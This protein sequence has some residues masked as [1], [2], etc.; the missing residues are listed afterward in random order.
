VRALAE[1]RSVVLASA[2]ASASGPSCAPAPTNP[3]PLASEVP[4]AEEGPSASLV[5]AGA[6]RVCMHDAKD[7]APCTEDCDRGVVFACTIVATRTERGDGV[8]KDLTRAVQLYERACEL[9]DGP[10]CVSAARMYASGRG[11]PPSRPKQIQLLSSACTLGDSHACSIPANAFATG[12]GVPRDE[13]RATELWQRGCA[14]GDEAACERVE[15][16]AP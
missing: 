5:E 3:R 8:A 14:G 1:L 6:P 11:V 12:G 16:A 7:L 10:S 9:R 15:G 13:R 2:L 4:R